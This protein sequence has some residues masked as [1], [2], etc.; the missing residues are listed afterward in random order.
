MKNK[1]VISESVENLALNAEPIC[2]RPFLEK[3]FKVMTDSEKSPED[4]VSVIEKMVRA[5]KPAETEQNTICAKIK[6]WL[7]KL[8][9]KTVKAFF[10]AV[11]GKWGSE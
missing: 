10:D 2:I 7:W 11:L 4:G 6:A 9:E 8:Y 1:Y 3:E 5:E